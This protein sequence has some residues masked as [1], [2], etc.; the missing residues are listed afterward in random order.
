MFFKDLLTVEMN[1]FEGQ[2]PPALRGIRPS[3]H[4][5]VHTTDDTIHS[6]VVEKPRDVPYTIDTHIA[7]KVGQLYFNLRLGQFGLTSPLW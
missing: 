1:K 5:I 3:S 7:L 2:L 4:C 6:A